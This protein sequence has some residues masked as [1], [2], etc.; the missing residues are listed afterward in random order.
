MAEMDFPVDLRSGLR[1]GPVVRQ[2]EGHL[3]VRVA[4]RF[5]SS[6]KPAQIGAL[7]SPHDLEP[8]L[9]VLANTGVPVPTEH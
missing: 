4:D 2:S 7:A 3:Y 6:W 5:L 8:R 9:R 1:P